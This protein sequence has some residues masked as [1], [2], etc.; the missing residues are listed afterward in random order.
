MQSAYYLQ[1]K[2]RYSDRSDR[3]GIGYYSS[4]SHAATVAKRLINKPGFRNPE[5]AFSIFHCRLDVS[6]WPEG[7]D[8]PAN[9]IPSQTVLNTPT[10]LQ[11][12]DRLYVAY[13]DNLHFDD[14][15]VLVGI[16]TTTDLANTELAR[17]RNIIKIEAGD[18][19]EI[20]ATVVD[21]DN[22]IDGF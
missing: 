4:L 12:G 5:G 22:W 13:I 21:Q 16:F 10:G 18:E 3:K 15:F 7:F 19:F 9:L 11:K 1:H 20:S 2:I 8:Q 6:Y 14:Q 17:L